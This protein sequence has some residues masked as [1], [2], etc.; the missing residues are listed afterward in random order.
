MQHHFN[1]SIAQ[2][3]GVNVAIFM[4]NMAFWIQKNIANQKHLYDDNYWTYNTVDAYT[5]LF[6]Y[7]TYKQVRTVILKC[8]EYG[9]IVEGNYNKSAYDR[10]KWYGLTTEGQKITGIAICQKGQMNSPDMANQSDQKGEPIPDTAS[11]T[12]TDNKSSCTQPPKNPKAKTKPKIRK[13]HNNQEK[14]HWAANAKVSDPV[15]QDPV[16]CGGCGRPNHHCYC[17]AN[18]RLPKEIAK[19]FSKAALAKLGRKSTQH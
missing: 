12:K 19:A 9:L 2:K 16:M 14:H 10:T 5:V 1:I 11:Y 8:V 15:T 4:D 3:Y 6:P 13:D 7:W 18:T 17:N